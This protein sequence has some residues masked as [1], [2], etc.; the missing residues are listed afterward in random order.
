MLHVSTHYCRIKSNNFGV[1]C[2]LLFLPPTHAVSPPTHA[3]N[4]LK[5][6]FVLCC[7][8]VI[9]INFYGGRDVSSYIGI[10]IDKQLIISKIFTGAYGGSE[11]LNTDRYCKDK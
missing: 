6:L 11:R 4:R 2:H 10:L 1:I 7:L 5:G 8:Y 3:I 9:T